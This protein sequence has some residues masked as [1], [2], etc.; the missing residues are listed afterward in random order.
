M[1]NGAVDEDVKDLEELI[2]EAV[3]QEDEGSASTRQIFLEFF[4]KRLNVPINLLTD[5]NGRVVVWLHRCL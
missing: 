1:P 4:A 3:D 2:E 5:F